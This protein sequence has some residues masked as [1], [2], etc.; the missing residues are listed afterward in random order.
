MLSGLFSS[1]LLEA[2]R[3]GQAVTAEDRRRE[4][5]RGAIKASIRIA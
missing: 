5:G 3:L 4:D 2:K 1:L